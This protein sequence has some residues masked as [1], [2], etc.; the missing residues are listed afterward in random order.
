LYYSETVKTNRNKAYYES[1]NEHQGQKKSQAWKYIIGEN[2]VSIIACKIREDPNQLYIYEELPKILAS[3]LDKY[4]I[5]IIGSG[6]VG[7]ATG[8][9]F[10]RLGHNVI[11]FDISKH[12]LAT[13]SEEGY[14]V[15]SSL[16]EAIS[17][18]E[19]TFVC[20]NTPHGG[21]KNVGGNYDEGQDLLNEDLGKH[22]DL[23]QILSASRELAVALNDNA[24][25]KRHL[26]FRSTMLPGTIR[27]VVIDYLDANCNLKRGKDYDVLYNPEF[28]RQN[29]AL[30]DF[31]NPDRVVIGQEIAGSSSPLSDLYS[32]LTKNIIITGYEEAEMIKYASNCFLALKI[33]Y[34]NQI[35]MMCKKMGINAEQVSLAASLDNRI[36]SY[37]T[38][39]GR[40]FGGSCFPKDTEA[41]ASF[42]SKMDMDPDLIETAISINKQIDDLS[43]TKLYVKKKMTI[44]HNIRESEI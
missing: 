25:E 17:T 6:V 41:F 26:V 23:S 13:L 32:S 31:F 21:E 10:H 8:K 19:I 40:P 4:N 39:G 18:S 33:S 9:G 5:S 12:R 29:S 20:V 35:E 22:Q 3:Y 36:G 43:S 34:F 42:A 30:D 14:N 44:D 27:N 15:A 11:F 7:S 1:R 28:L 2:S 16:K 37:G 24:I 38:R